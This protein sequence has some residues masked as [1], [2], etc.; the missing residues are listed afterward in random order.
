M[1]T[2]V[3]IQETWLEQSVIGGGVRAPCGDESVHPL[4]INMPSLFCVLSAR[5]QPGTVVRNSCTRKCAIVLLLIQK[6][7][8]ATSVDRIPIRPKAHQSAMKWC[9]R[10]MYIALRNASRAEF[11]EPLPSLKT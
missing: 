7:H 2:T 9:Q 1:R 8:F 5:E 11:V 10:A 6:L 3:G 4:S